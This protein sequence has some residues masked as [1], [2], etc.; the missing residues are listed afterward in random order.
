MRCEMDI[1]VLVVDDDP[2]MLSL[3]QRHLT[4]D[5]CGVS[6]ANNG[7]DALRLLVSQ[8]PR[9]VITD[10]MM[11]G[12][13][14]LDL[15]RA[16]RSSPHVGFTYILVLTAHTD[17][18]R[19]VEAFEA[20]ADDFLSKPFQ[21]E[22]LRARLN[23]G[24]RISRMQEELIQNNQALHE[25]N[26]EQAVLN[27][28]LE[29]M[30]TT[31]LLTGLANRR[32][33]MAQLAEYWSMTGRSHQPLA[34][35]SLDIDHFK[36]VNDTHGHEA[37]DAVLRETARV[38]ARFTRV[39]ASPCRIGGEEFLILCPNGT[40]RAAAAG[41]ERLRRAVESNRIR[42]KGIDLSVTVSAGVAQRDET[43]NTPGA[44]L[45]QADEAM[46]AAKRAG[47]NRVCLAG[48]EDADLLP[49]PRAEERHA[50]RSCSVSMTP[51]PE[52]LTRVMIADDDA[53]TRALCRRFLEQAGYQVREAVNGL[54]ALAKIREMATDV[55]IMDAM[56]PHMDGLEC[57]RRLKADPGTRNIPVIMA[58]VRSRPR[59]VVAGLEAGVDEY[60]A[61]PI[62][63]KE[64][65]LRVRSVAT[66]HHRNLQLVRTNALQSEQARSLVSYGGT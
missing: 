45:K 25:A 37:G 55:V 65:L 14:G 26:A 30:A 3:L 8:A 10:W 42:C 33:A 20:G 61:K 49:R 41:A 23:A 17:K 18:G 66:L 4:E 5:G 64:F 34:C 1:K 12:M 51:V 62:R 63:Q 27:R 2:S 60:I 56:M 36:H 31:D 47:R 13:D 21:R 29:Q 7:A 39:G 9:I 58:S 11:P 35:I 52:S 54:D 6:S 43:I 57:T 32:R 53:S 59:D 40:G 22:E 15:C 28:K 46:Y 48:D 44:L 50:D 16:I 19:L 38:L 24:I